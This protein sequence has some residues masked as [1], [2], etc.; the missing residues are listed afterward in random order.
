M[1]TA[2]LQPQPA[3]NDPAELQGTVRL[4]DLPGSVDPGSASYSSQQPYDPRAGV[5]MPQD[6]CKQSSSPAPA[7]SNFEVAMSG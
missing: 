4:L 3:T 6:G 7:S 1:A 5:D 2:P